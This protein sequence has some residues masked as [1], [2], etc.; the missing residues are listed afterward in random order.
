MF[1]K[2]SEQEVLERLSLRKTEVKCLDKLPPLDKFY[3]SFV[4][5][6][7]DEEITPDIEVLGYE[8]VV[9]ENRY[10]ATNYTN[11]SKMVWLIGRTGQGDQWFIKRD[12]G[13]ILFYDHNQGE[14]SNMK[15]FVSLHIG[16][17]DFLQM[18]FLYQD[19]EILLN[20]QAEATKDQIINF[21]KTINS[22]Y[23][24]LYESYPFGYFR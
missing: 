2:L 9:K 19:L 7:E 21:I 16:F 5:Q 3:I 1:K 4:S 17:S 8:K 23:P 15:Q 14:Y 18:A 6:Y 12:N 22:I 24:N 11:I 20:K 10:L 13:V